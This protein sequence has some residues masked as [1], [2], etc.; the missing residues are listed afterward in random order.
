MDRLRR[1]YREALIKVSQGHAFN[2]EYDHTCQQKMYGCRYCRELYPRYDNEETFYDS[3]RQY[4]IVSQ[5]R[6]KHYSRLVRLRAEVKA[7]ATPTACSPALSLTNGGSRSTGAGRERLAAMEPRVQYWSDEFTNTLI[8]NSL[9]RAQLGELASVVPEIE[10]AWS[11]ALHDRYVVENVIPVR[12]PDLATTFEQLI[13][14]H[15]RLGDSFVHGDWSFVV[16]ETPLRLDPSLSSRVDP[17]TSATPV[18]SSLI[19]ISPGHHDA[20]IL[21]PRSWETS[22]RLGNS[23]LSS[24]RV[25]GI[26]YSTA[27]GG[28]NIL[29]EDEESITVSHP[30]ASGHCTLLMFL[31]RLMSHPATYCAVGNDEY[32]VRL[33]EEAWF[34]ESLDIID[35]RLREY[36]RRPSSLVDLIRDVRL[37]KN[38]ATLLLPLVPMTKNM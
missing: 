27:D 36:H 22:I 4:L 12:L 34:P 10:G 21:T 14:V 16:S 15:A 32:L 24:I 30:Y 2:I 1:Q 19:S 26:Q 13:L 35:Q 3:D 28:G 8:V 25:G 18:S 9:L 33:W 17:L 29:E 7:L 37:K 6:M 23:G 20:P 31:L 5:P 38:V 11:C